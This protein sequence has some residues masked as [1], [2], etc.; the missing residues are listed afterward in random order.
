VPVARVVAAVRAPVEVAVAAVV[1]PVV[2]AVVGSEAASP[3]RIP[4]AP[5]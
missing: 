5:A 4:S 2:L 1:V 3:C